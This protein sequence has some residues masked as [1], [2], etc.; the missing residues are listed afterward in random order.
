MQVPGYNSGDG[1]VSHVR[2]L[3]DGT[4]KPQGAEKPRGF[5][6]S[7]YFPLYIFFRPSYKQLNPFL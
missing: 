7:Q 1:I 6:P 3:I 5:H 4:E 2:I